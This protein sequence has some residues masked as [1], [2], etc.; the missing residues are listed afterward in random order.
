MRQEAITLHH[1]WL[2]SGLQSEACRFG[3]LAERFSRAHRTESF[4][5]DLNWI[6]NVNAVSPRHLRLA[7][8]LLSL[9]LPGRLLALP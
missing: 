7:A 5:Y 6:N 1:I 2:A 9:R 4:T 3:T 8:A